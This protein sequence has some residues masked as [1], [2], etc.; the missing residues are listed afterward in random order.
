MATQRKL[1]TFVLLFLLTTPASAAVVGFVSNII[2]DNVVDL[3]ANVQQGQIAYCKANSKMYQYDGAAWNQIYNS[4]VAFSSSSVSFQ[5]ISSTPWTTT[6][7]TNS[8]TSLSYLGISSATPGNLSLSSASVSYLGVSSTT[9]G[10]LSLSSAAVSYLGVSSTPASSL[11]LSSA[12]VSY[13]AISTDA[14]KLTNSSA[15]AVYSQITANNTNYL[16]I[17]SA[18]TAYLGVSSTSANSLT[19]SSAAVSY[20]AISTDALKV[21]Y[22]SNSVSSLNISS[23]NV[24]GTGPS[25][26][27]PVGAGYTF[28]ATTNTITVAGSSVTVTLT[29]A[30]TYLLFG[31][32]NLVY[33]AATFAANQFITL[34]IYRQNN[35]PGVVPNAF[36]QGRTR[37]ITTITDEAGYYEIPVVV[38]T[39]AN[40]TDVLSFHGSVSV[41]PSAGSL[42]ASRASLLAVRIK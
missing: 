10:N 2:V 22:S 40:T 4:G 6:T 33:N 16:A 42:Q 25:L 17:S 26:Y 21:T 9:P 29:A 37:I 18:A 30:G 7:I 38:Y 3:P 23:F 41:I 15:T 20:T 24:L 11:S 27:S 28:T 35:T 14:L 31:E 36:I 34:A 5:S 1:R 32:A 8:S 19:L 39:T 12:S 13:T